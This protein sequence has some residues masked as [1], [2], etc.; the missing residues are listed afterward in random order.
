[1]ILREGKVELFCLQKWSADWNRIYC[2]VTSVCV[3]RFVYTLLLKR[4]S[5]VKKVSSGSKSNGFAIHWQVGV[6]LMKI[7]RRTMRMMLKKALTHKLTSRVVS[8]DL[9]TARFKCH[10]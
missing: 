9:L 6:V 4:N 3:F 1:M 10:F 7:L 2:V 8:R 5:E